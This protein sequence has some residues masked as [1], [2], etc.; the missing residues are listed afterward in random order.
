ME[1]LSNAVIESLLLD[2]PVLGSDGVSIN[3]LVEDGVSGALVPIGDAE[4]LAAAMLSVWRREA[5]WCHSGFRMPAILSDMKPEAA[6]SNLLHL[7]GF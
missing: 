2:V 4:A 5:Q 6:A 3:E 7:A 1:N